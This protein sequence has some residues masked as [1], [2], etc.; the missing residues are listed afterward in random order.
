[1]VDFAFFYFRRT[2]LCLRLE[3][4]SESSISGR[5]Q[6][7]PHYWIERYGEKLYAYTIKRVKNRELAEDII[8]D[9]FLSALRSVHQFR[10]T[11]SESTYLISILK[12]KIIDFYRFRNSNK[13]KSEVRFLDVIQEWTGNW[14][15][16]CVDTPSGLSPTSYVETREL[17]RVI[18]SFLDTINERHADIFRMKVIHA[19]DNDT[20]MKKHG[21]SKDNIWVISHRVK[22]KICYH[23]RKNGY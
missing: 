2:K 16:D 18:N 22:K 11:C 4:Q 23:L 3:I 13:Y 1:M 6:L 9:T 17:Y 19:V 12:R 15:E 14:L 21:V 5:T 20:I 7:N 8:S 10:G